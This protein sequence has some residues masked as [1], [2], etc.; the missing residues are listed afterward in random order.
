MPW[1][2]QAVAEAPQDAEAHAAYLAELGKS[3]PQGVMQHVEEHPD[4]ASEAV[5]AHYLSALVRSGR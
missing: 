2:L 1:L 4:A 5:V 3:D